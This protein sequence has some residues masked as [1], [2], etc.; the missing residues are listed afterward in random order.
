MK[1]I[2]RAGILSLVFMFA[3]MFIAASIAVAAAGRFISPTD[4]GHIRTQGV[5]LQAKHDNDYKENPI[6]HIS[7]HD[8]TLEK[9][10]S[11]ILKASLLPGGKSVSVEWYSSNPEIVNVSSSGKITAVASGIAMI[12]AINDKYSYQ[13]DMTGSSN[14]CFVI[15]PSGA[16]DAKPLDTSDR[17]YS[18]GKTILT[19]PSNKYPSSKYKEALTKIKKSI[20]GYEYYDKDNDR[21]GLLFGSK[22]VSKAH[23]FIY[24]KGTVNY[25]NYSYG[26]GFIAMDKSPIKTSRGIGIGAK[27][28][29]VLQKYGLPT[30]KD[31]F[32][33]NDGK[34]LETYSYVAKVLKTASYT[35]MTFNFL[36]SKGTVIEISF[37]LGIW[38]WW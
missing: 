12:S 11:Y 2:T 20:G 18:Y 3:F 28:S 36:E 37:L 27:K 29:T 16:K 31:T 35:R 15:V 25:I 17:T 14:D 9:G 26:F 5:Q 32:Y 1:K 8:L 7:K 24:Y 10:K 33:S 22:D 4:K 34:L 30:F 21:T 13:N 23:T 19:A 38:G 6:I